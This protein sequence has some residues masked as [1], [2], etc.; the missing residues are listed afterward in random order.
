MRFKVITVHGETATVFHV[1]D[2]EAPEGEQPAIVH[3]YSS[4]KLASMANRCANCC[5]DVLNEAHKSALK[6]PV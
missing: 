5:R 4:A 1:V 3:S 6:S 2:S